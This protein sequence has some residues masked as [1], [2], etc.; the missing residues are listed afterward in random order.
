MKSNA[1]RALLFGALL[2]VG[3]CSSASKKAPDLD[4]ALL[5]EVKFQA[6]SP[7]VVQL[8]IQN[9]REVNR[10]A[11]NASEVEEAVRRALTNALKRGGVKVKDTAL[12]KFIVVISDY[13]SRSMQGEC[14]KVNSELRARWGNSLVTEG[15]GC[16]QLKHLVG[17]SLGG[18]LSEAY[19]QALSMTLEY[20]ENNQ[21]KLIGH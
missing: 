11:G 1:I 10:A 16:H 13:P 21:M 17:F 19:R 3:G 6:L 8:S 2:F 9:K 14:V 20:L 4:G 7:R 15:Y 12:N 18:D 5:P